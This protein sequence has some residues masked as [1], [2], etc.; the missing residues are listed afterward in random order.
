MEK[1]LEMTIC[2][3]IHIFVV[4]LFSCMLASPR[5]FIVLQPA[6]VFFDQVEE[7]KGAAAAATRVPLHD[8]H[9]YLTHDIEPRLETT[10]CGGTLTHIEDAIELT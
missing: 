9:L 2:L 3:D 10:I 4:F 6:M 8:A 5:L 7:Y 1:V